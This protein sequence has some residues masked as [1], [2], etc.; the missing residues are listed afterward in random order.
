[1]VILKAGKQ[2]KQ[3]K[4][5]IAASG[6]TAFLI[7]NCGMEGEKIYSGTDSMPDET[8]YFSLMIVKS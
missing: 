1:M 4:Q 3:I 6:K 2:L 7:E 8:G 5:R